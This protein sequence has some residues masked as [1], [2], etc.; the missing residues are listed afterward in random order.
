MVYAGQVTAEGV[1]RE[2]HPQVHLHYQP[3]A[4]PGDG[5]CLWHAVSITSLM[6]DLRRATTTI[7]KDHEQDF[8]RMLAADV[9]EYTF[10]R[11]VTEASTVNCWGNEYHIQALEVA[12]NRPVIQYTGFK[13]AGGQFHH[14]EASSN[15][16]QALFAQGAPGTRQHLIYDPLWTPAASHGKPIC[17]VLQ[18]RHFTDQL[19]RDAQAPL[20]YPITRLLALAVNGN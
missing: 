1:A 2:I 4:T 7:L 10:E 17:I 11:L 13:A 6:T 15:R 18:N 19:P 3:V 16:L 14:P 12:L 5:N 8:R 20:F 9:T